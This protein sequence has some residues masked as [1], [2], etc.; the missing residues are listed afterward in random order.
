MKSLIFP[1]IVTPARA[2][3]YN[4]QKIMDY[5]ICRNDGLIYIH[6]KIN[7]GYSAALLN[8]SVYGYMKAA[9]ILRFNSDP[10]PVL[11]NLLPIAHNLN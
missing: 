4:H 5:G 9:G 3:V 2:G 1:T 6:G 11:D 8:E 10:Q 7:P